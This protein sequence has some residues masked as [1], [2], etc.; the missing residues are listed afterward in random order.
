MGSFRHHFTN[1]R[2]GSPGMFTPMSTGSPYTPARYHYGYDHQFNPLRDYSPTYTS[3]PYQNR[4]G[5]SDDRS[6]I[7]SNGSHQSIMSPVR[8]RGGLNS[9][10]MYNGPNPNNSVDIGRIQVGIDVRTTVSTLS[11]GGTQLTQIRSCFVIFPT[12][13]IKPS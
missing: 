12:K 6:F 13:S 2:Q 9:A 5:G 4:Y 10:Q 8:N 3:T 11:M 1:A 7:R